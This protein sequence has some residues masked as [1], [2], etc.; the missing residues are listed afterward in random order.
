MGERHDP[1]NSGCGWVAWF[2]GLP[3]SGKSSVAA[4]VRASLQ[5]RGIAVRLLQMDVQRKHYFPHPKYTAEERRRAYTLFAEEAA[6]L[7]AAGHNV[8]M[9]GTAPQVAMRE[10]ARALAPCFAEIHIQCRLETA[11]YRESERE[12]GMVMAELYRKALHRQRTGEQ[13][14]GL[15][16]VVGVDVEFE[17]NPAA[18]CVIPNDDISLAAARDAVLECFEP[19]RRA[20]QRD[21][22][23]S[24]PK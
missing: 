4:A 22:A 10:Y 18:E 14:E 5:A 1:R 3:G 24:K 13:F 23:E 21:H 11:M 19:W 16:Q 9:D 20:V 15:G 8:F 7:A 6:A 2:V 17:T 12:G